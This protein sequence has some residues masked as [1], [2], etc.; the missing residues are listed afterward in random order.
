MEGQNYLIL[1]SVEMMNASCDTG[2]IGE[3]E[4]RETGYFHSNERFDS[5]QSK[6]SHE[7]YGFKA[8]H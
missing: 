1:K 4:K 7:F 5:S 2:D 8:I 3:M 6:L